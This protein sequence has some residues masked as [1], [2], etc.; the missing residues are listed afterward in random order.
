M[1]MHPL[2]LYVPLAPLAGAVIAGLFGKAIGRA[3]AHWITSL[4]V[5]VSLVLSWLIF[6]DVDAG[7]IYNAAVYT[8]ASSGGISVWV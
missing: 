1:D 8:W 5:A 3:G 7:Q 4:G 2:A 6:Q